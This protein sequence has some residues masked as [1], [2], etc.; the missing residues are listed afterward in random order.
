MATDSEIVN[1][2]FDMLE[3]CL[4][5]NDTLN[6]PGQIFNCDETGIPLNPFPDVAG[7]MRHETFLL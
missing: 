3:E 7:Y 6:K 1:K 4:Q 5:Q 2:Y